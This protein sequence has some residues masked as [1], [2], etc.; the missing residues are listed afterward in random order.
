MLVAQEPNSPAPLFVLRPEGLVYPLLILSTMES[1][2]FC[3]TFAIRGFRRRP[4]LSALLPSATELRP[5]KRRA[6]PTGWRTL[7]LPV[8][9]R[10]LVRAEGKRV[11]LQDHHEVRER[12]AA[13]QQKV[14][15]ST[16]GRFL[17]DLDF[18]GFPRGDLLFV[19]RFL[20]AGR[21]REDFLLPHALAAG[22]HP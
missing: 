4:D 13:S 18:R 22:G 16:V 5:P 20:Q 11:V 2:I 9:F 3:R 19:G 12:A 21:A 15:R 7:T 14:I 17:E 1:Q 10:W 6:S 8:V